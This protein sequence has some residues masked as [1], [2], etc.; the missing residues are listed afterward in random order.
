MPNTAS[1]LRTYRFD[2]MAIMINDR[3]D[4]PAASGVERYVGLEHLD[5]DSLR[6]RRWGD[7]TDVES[8]K[9][10][11]TPGDIIFGKRRVYQRK[12]AVA[13]FEGICSA[14][15][16]VLR[17]RPDV[18]LPEFLPFFMQSELFMERALAISV[19]SLSPT[20]NWTDL[21][22]QEFPVPSIEEQHQLV[23]LLQALR[24]TAERQEEAAIA[25]RTMRSSLVR[26]LLGTPTSGG[27]GEQL[28]RV[29]SVCRVV[30][31]SSPRPAGDP[32]YFNGSHIPWITVGEITKD[33]RIW[34]TETATFLT[35]SGMERSRILNS[36][37]VVL[38]NSGFSLGVPKVLQIT[39]C[40]ND[41]VAAFVNLDPCV[42]PLFLYYRL[43]GMTRYLREVVAAGGDQPNLNT[44]RIGDLLLPLP[45][46]ERQAEVVAELRVAEEGVEAM[47]T[48]VSQIRAFLGDVTRRQ[49]TTEAP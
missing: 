20:I 10:R 1:D 41:G 22:E 38:T 3:V 14:H 40:A 30:R 6:I 24:A 36:G 15:A 42:Q 47:T 35:E 23:A 13:D 21:A 34:L 8:T 7:I 11:F 45:S 27:Q 18:V 43:L 26:K 5:T 48:R 4:D 39:G 16:M 28:V 19:G 12:L 25:A 9:L 44:D 49:L 46:L 17:A 32:R 33:D 2:Q 37:T 29:S 31:G